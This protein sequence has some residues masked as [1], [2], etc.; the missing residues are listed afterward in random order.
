MGPARGVLRA[1]RPAGGP[2]SA[3]APRG[4]RA[5][6]GAGA[7][8]AATGAWAL[9]AAAAGIEQGEGKCGP[10]PVAWWPRPQAAAGY[11]AKQAKGSSRR[12]RR[13][14][15]ERG[16]AHTGA[17]ALISTRAAMCRRAPAALGPAAPARRGATGAR[18]R[19][20]VGGGEAGRAGPKGRACGGPPARSQRHAAEKGNT[21]AAKSPVPDPRRFSG[22]AAGGAASLTWRAKGGWAATVG[23][24]REAGPWRGARRRG[25]RR[26]RA[27]PRRPAALTNE[28]RPRAAAVERGRTGR[29]GGGGLTGQ[30]ARGAGP[31]KGG[32]GRGCVRGC[33]VGF[34][35]Q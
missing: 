30:C 24:R 3:G 17:L 19:R 20:Q 1:V 26:R 11:Q 29:E 5:G 34:L 7:P 25:A 16:R 18:Q 35:S 8:P 14:P 12:P 31:E 15:V 32:A 9:A 23:R 28:R 33:A 6:R 10:Q 22:A 13:R 21:S 4:P 27:G 2:R